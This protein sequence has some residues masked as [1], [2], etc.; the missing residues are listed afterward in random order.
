MGT[1]VDE[2]EPVSAQTAGAPSASAER[3]LRP[4]TSLRV[5][6][7]SCHLA[8]VVNRSTGVKKGVEHA[9]HQMHEAIELRCATAYDHTIV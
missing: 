3:W 8:V 9:P 5:S 4:A 7:T 6:K 2:R 1:G